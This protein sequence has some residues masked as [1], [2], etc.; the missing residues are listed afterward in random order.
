MLFLFKDCSNDDAQPANLYVVQIIHY[1]IDVLCVCVC[2]LFFGLFVFVVA[3]N[4]Y[5]NDII[6][7]NSSSSKKTK[8]FIIYIFLA[9]SSLLLLVSQLAIITFFVFVVYCYFLVF[10]LCVLY[11]DLVIYM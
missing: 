1:Y 6:T 9:F 7:I 4:R 8:L 5:W 2:V 3:T 10:E 11:L